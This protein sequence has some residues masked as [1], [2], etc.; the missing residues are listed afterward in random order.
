MCLN[1][2]VIVGLVAVAV[3]VLAID[4]HVFT[5]V[6]PFLFFAIC[7]LSMVLMM[8]GMRKAGGMQNMSGSSQSCGM[9]S[10]SGGIMGMDS[11]DMRPIGSAS[12]DSATP[13]NEVARLRAEVDQLRAE[14]STRT[15]GEAGL[16]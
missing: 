6:L 2:K 7:P 13:E 12:P 11:T 5:H 1:R 15:H 4:P 14:L 3:G 10:S 9:S 16:R 8:W